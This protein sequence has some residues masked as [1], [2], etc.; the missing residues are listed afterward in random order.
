MS[1]PKESRDRLFKYGRPN[2]RQ[3][4]I[5]EDGVICKDMAVIWGAYRKGSFGMTELSQEEFTERFIEHISKYYA[6]WIVEDKNYRF[7]NGYGAIGLIFAKFNGW[8]MEPE[9]FPFSWATD[10]NKLKMVVS[11][12]MMARYEKGIGTLNFTTT[13]EEFYQHLRKK[14]GVMY[15]VG[16]VPRGAMG[17][18]AY[19]FYGRGKDFFKR[20]T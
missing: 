14:Y 11:F 1:K 4:D 6:V 7:P 12:M 17:K 13:E 2:I 10:R 15:Y 19:L 3:L 8:S 9:F 5:L 18:D 20:Q 16:K